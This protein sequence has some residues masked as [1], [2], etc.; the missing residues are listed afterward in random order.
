MPVA[1][2]AKTTKNR[3]NKEA[4]NWNEERKYPA[5]AKWHTLSFPIQGAKKLIK[6]CFH[7]SFFISLTSLSTVANLPLAKLVQVVAHTVEGEANLVGKMCYNNRL[8]EIV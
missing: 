4:F 7:Y 6:S 8:V 3:E 5:A 2:S 1:M